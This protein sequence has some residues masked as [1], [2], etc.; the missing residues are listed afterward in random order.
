MGLVIFI[1]LFLIAFVSLI[2][3]TG[4]YY[5]VLVLSLF[6]LK[7]I[8]LKIL[9][10]WGG[11]SSIYMYL[12]ILI[13]LPVLLL[14]K[15][16]WLT[17]ENK[18]LITRLSLSILLLFVYLFFSALFKG[19]GFMN[20]VL[21]PKNFFYGYVLFIYL[22]LEKSSFYRLVNRL[23]FSVLIIEVFLG[24]LQYIGPDSFSNFF[25]I[26]EYNWNGGKTQLLGKSFYVNKLVLGTLLRPAQFADLISLLAIY[27]GG[28]YVYNRDLFF[29][30]KYYLVILII[31]V[32]VIFFT[33]IRTAVVS[34]FVGV[35]LLNYSKSKINLVFFSFLILVILFFFYQS[36]NQISSLSAT[37]KIGINNPIERVSGLITVFKD[38]NKLNQD[39]A[40]TLIRSIWLFPYV[41]LNPLFGAGLYWQAGY[42]GQLA[43]GSDLASWSD[44]TIMFFLVEFG[45]VGLFLFVLP[46]VIILRYAKKNIQKQDFYIILSVFFTLVIQTITD[47]GL[48]NINSSMIFFLLVGLEVNKQRTA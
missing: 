39:N 13:L 15:G 45:L 14:K 31:S 9:P 29:N 11:G 42:Y 6:F 48:F 47:P 18:K 43:A 19:V 30:R 32:V 38:V 44:A 33:G 36:Y 21:F 10:D 23:L 25:K 27:F 4:I 22:I 35:L 26:I 16:L 28:K 41:H 40:L 7:F 2:R 8:M 24:I 12:L 5:I 46:Y 37:G 34:V 3:G 17:V 1:F 20:Y